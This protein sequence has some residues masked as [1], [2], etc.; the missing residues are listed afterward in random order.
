MYRQIEEM[1]AS[2]IGVAP[3][4]RLTVAVGE[5]VKVTLK[6]KYRGP[7]RDGQIH[8]T[9]GSQNGTFNEDGNKQKDIPA[10]FDSHAED[11]EYTFTADVAI[12]GSGGIFDLYAKI[13]G[14]SGATDVF[15]PIYLDVLEVE[16]VGAPMFSNFRITDYSKA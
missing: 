10:H 5:T 1:L 8:V 7:M 15:T 2:G 3:P 14:I 16:V 12:K 9:F 13:M 6:V 11:R 4:Q